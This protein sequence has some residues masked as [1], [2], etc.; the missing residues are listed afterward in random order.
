MLYIC[1]GKGSHVYRRVEGIALRFKVQQKGIF[2]TKQ[3]STGGIHVKAQHK[4]LDLCRALQEAHDI[5]V[6]F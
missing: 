1:P 2:V 3:A 4:A 6:D 5:L